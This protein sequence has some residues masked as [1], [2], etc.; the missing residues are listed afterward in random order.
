MSS[1]YSLTTDQLEF[2]DFAREFAAKEIAPLSQLH[3]AK[4]MQGSELL[5][6]ICQSGLVNVRIPEEYGG[7]GLSLVETCL[8]LEELSFG[9]SGISLIAEA[10]ELAL[11][12][13]LMLGTS[14][15][16]SSYLSILTSSNSLAGYSLPCN[17]QSP[18]RNFVRAKN[19]KNT[20]VLDGQAPM[21]LNAGFAQWFVLTCPVEGTNTKQNDIVQYSS[22]IIPKDMKGLNISQPI[23]SFGRRAGDIRSVDFDQVQ[24]E[25][26][27]ELH[28]PAGTYAGS[29]ALMPAMGS[30]IASGSIGLA[31][32]AFEKAKKYALERKTFGAPIARHQAISFMMADILTDIEAMQSMRDELLISAFHSRNN[33]K[34]A[35]SLLQFSLNAAIRISTDAV[36]ILG[37]YGYTR[38]Y[39]VEKLMR[40][41][42]ASECLY[43]NAYEDYLARS[44][45]D[46]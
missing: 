21:V 18:N 2:K 8:I 36:Q 17:Y 43:Q 45:I 25:V 44:L 9:C 3:E 14:E 19:E 1:I 20:I 46:S 35:A 30:I 10:S 40:D 24:L 7:P 16:K 6:K 29:M 37:G 13:L 34:L 28:L 11:T 41:A 4:S 39:E 5:K 22:F 26:G 27:A 33:F 15:Q 31:R 42:K 12:S 32:A 23:Q 38:E